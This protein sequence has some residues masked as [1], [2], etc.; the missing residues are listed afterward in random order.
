MPFTKVLNL[1]NFSFRRRSK[2]FAFSRISSVQRLK[3]ESTLARSES[4]EIFESGFPIIAVRALNCLIG[5][6]ECHPYL[7]NWSIIRNSYL[8]TNLHKHN[9]ITL[10]IFFPPFRFASGSRAK[11]QFIDSLTFGGNL[12]DF[13]MLSNPSG[14]RRRQ[15]NARQTFFS[16]PRSS[17]LFYHSSDV[18]GISSPW[19]PWRRL[20]HPS[21]PI[22]LSIQVNLTIYYLSRSSP[23]L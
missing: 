17:Q 10:A 14:F 3:R 19:H 9:S 5:L 20:I 4:N 12:R 16:R 21:Q 1:L 22:L 23:L 15:Q 7:I 2:H 18:D 11:Y 13:Q 8:L 6:S